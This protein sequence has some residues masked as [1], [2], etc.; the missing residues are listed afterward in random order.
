QPDRKEYFVET[1]RYR[2]IVR[3]RFGALTPERRDALLA[4]APLH[5]AL[6]AQFTEAGSL[7]YDRA[8]AFFAF[9]YQVDVEG[10]SA[11]AC[12]A[13][14]PVIGELRALEDLDRL[15]LEARDG[16]L[17]VSVTCLSEMRTER[18][19]GPKRRPAVT[20]GA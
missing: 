9:R 8:L 14:A 7:T 12:D 1:R 6:K 10:E 18:K 19:K 20:T 16:K 17:T 13:E 3:G 5:D 15:G 11:D 4:D 2:I